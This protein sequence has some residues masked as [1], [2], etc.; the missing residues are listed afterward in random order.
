MS[1]AHIYARNLGA[2]WLGHAANL[3]V[4]FLMSPFVVHG[5][6]DTRYG[7]W[8]LLTSLTGY[9]G[10]VD[11]GVRGGTGRY[12]NYYLGRKEDDQVSNVVST[13]LLFYAV[14]SVLVFAASVALAFFFAD[15]FPKIQPEYV[16]EAQWVLLLL[17]LNVWVG[18]FSSTFSQLLIAAERFDL[19]MIADVIVLALRTAATI[20]VLTND[21]GLVE[22]AL[23]QVVSGVLGCVLTAGFARWKGPHTCIHWRHFRKA[24][25]VEVFGFGLWAFMGNASVQ[26]GLYASSAIIGMFIGSAEITLYS[27][28][29]MLSGYGSNFVGRITD[30]MVPD[31]MKAG[32][33]EDKADLQRLMGK[34][35]RATMFVAVPVLIGFMTLGGEFI[36]VW[37]G[38]GYTASAWVLLILATSQF[39]RLANRPI[40]ETLIALGRIRLWASMAAVESL[41]ALV[42]SVSLVLLTDL[43]IY[44]IAIGTAV[45]VIVTYN[46]W[47]FIVG[48]RTV[49]A[50]PLA[51]ARSTTLRWVVGAILF[52]IPCLLISHVIP[53]GGWL[54]FWLKVGIV[55]VLYVPIGL[56]VVLQQ[57]ESLATLTRAKSWRPWNAKAPA[58]EG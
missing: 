47:L 31:I 34:S 54:L 44:G 7:V 36:R 11:I 17:G 55:C 9:L 15:I 50:S 21:R 24:T 3:A 52:A 46:I 40:S 27:I 20:W 26:L 5:L 12:V 10:L 39:G 43:G 49:G 6:G 56:F 58:M 2:N 4:A 48:Y 42:C 1:K 14:V 18:F 35:T 25:F 53:H 16:H 41:A 57:S 33:R 29:S 28:G 51:V 45:P 32:G 23:V 19:Q 30:V 38:P 13:S 22:L 8:T 37:M